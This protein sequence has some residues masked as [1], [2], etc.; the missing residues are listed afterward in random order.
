MADV[1]RLPYINPDAPQVATPDY[2]GEYYDALAPA[3]LDLAERAR[4][5]VNAL[6][7]PLD[8][9]Y[10]YEL[11]WIADLL[12]R[13]PAM[14]HTV[15]DHVQAKFF[16]ALPLLRIASGSTQNLE[17]ERFLMQVHLRMQGPDGLTYFPIRG[18][19]WALPAKPDPW[20]GLDYLPAGDHWCSLHMVGRIL[21]GF[22]IYALLDPDGP[23][24][25]AAERLV[26]A[27]ARVII[28]EDDIAYLFLNCTEPGKPV[29][30][31][32]AK[33]VG[34]RAAF[35][36]WVAQALAQ[37]HLAL[38]N[39]TASDLALRM[40]RY[41]MRDAGYFG[42]SGEFREDLPG[43]T[44]FHSHTTQILAALE[45]VR[46]TGND[47]LLQAALRAYAYAVRRGE[48]LLGFFP[49]FLD[50]P[51]AT[52]NSELCE[53]ADMIACAVK[54]SLLGVDRWD[55]ADRWVRNQFAEGQLVQINWLSDGHIEPPAGEQGPPPQQY[56]TTER[57][58]ERCLGSF[59]GWPPPNDW[60]RGPG[61]SIM[62]CCTGNAARAIYYVWKNILSFADGSLRVN[63]LLN[64]ASQWA[65]VHSHIPY[66]G[67]VDIAVKRDLKL[68]VR[69]PEWVQPSAATCKVN[70]AH[71]E[72]AFD[73]RYARVGAV[74][75]G[76]QVALEFPIPERTDR[77]TIQGSA[78]TVTRRGNDVVY[79]DPPGKNCPLYQRGHYREGAPLWRKVVRFVPEREIEW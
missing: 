13:P 47:E 75:P 4:L 70:D 29:I 20:P 45:V 19:P 58:P 42:E 46:A 25:Q 63:L 21:G 38:G 65:D 48:P 6:T 60:V 7:E 15:D 49:E 27:M 62:H 55:D 41:V 3:T 68:E 12:A 78:F 2:R 43:L 74:K 61:A 32:A 71:R 72:L 73:G 59:A 14:Y 53:V 24:R 77:L 18:R 30:K 22:C 51:D 79:I 9:D 44:H 34:V 5:A 67:R 39:A 16:Q 64:R 23:W 76:D 17:V 1:P 40:M 57:V 33:P 26:E 52:E 8:P 28:R 11:Y 66:A 69:L 37:C 54:L 10:D 35:A 31:P 50:R 36:G 56:G